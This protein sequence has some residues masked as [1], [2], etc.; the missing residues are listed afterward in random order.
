MSLVTQLGTQLGTQLATNPDPPGTIGVSQLGHKA[1][2]HLGKPANTTA[3]APAGIVRQT[4][5]HQPRHRVYTGQDSGRDTGQDKRAIE[6]GTPLHSC[7]LLRTATGTPMRA[8]AGAPSG[9]PAGKAAETPGQ[10][11]VRIVDRWV[12]GAA[13]RRRRRRRTSSTRSEN[14]HTQ[15]RPMPT[16]STTWRLGNPEGCISSMHRSPH[17]HAGGDMSWCTFFAKRVD[18]GE[19]GG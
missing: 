15:T 16:R 10:Q 18:L 8:Q 6:P 9:I 4:A 5:R 19:H 13:G 12:Q 2:H 1:G 17:I 11:G 3:G 14:G 7:G